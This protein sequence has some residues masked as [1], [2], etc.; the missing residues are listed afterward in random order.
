MG[1]ALDT[2]HPI[3][4]KQL[5]PRYYAG[6]LIQQALSC[7]LLSERDIKRIQADLFVILS[8]QCDKWCRGES[9]SVPIEIGQDMMNSILFVISIRTCS[10][11][12]GS[13][14]TESV[15]GRY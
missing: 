12:S 1:E 15:I 2:L 9:S 6:S 8:E 4:E 11:K 5:H 7:R 13:S 3:D 10:A 14:K